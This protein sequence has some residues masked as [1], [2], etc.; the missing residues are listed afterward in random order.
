MTMMLGA[1]FNRA[2][3]ELKSFL[4]K[5]PV[6]RGYVACEA[7][8]TGEP[9]DYPYLCTPSAA[10]SCAPGVPSASFR[11]LAP[12]SAYP[13]LAVSSKDGPARYLA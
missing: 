12:G 3:L 6:R 9:F 7:G 2:D 5:K 11:E 10:A 8:P 1:T 13:G 4:V